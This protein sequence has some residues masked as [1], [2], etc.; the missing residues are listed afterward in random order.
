MNFSHQDDDTG[1]LA[2]FIALLL[3]LFIVGAVI[4]LFS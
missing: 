4:F 3:L 1:P 2:A